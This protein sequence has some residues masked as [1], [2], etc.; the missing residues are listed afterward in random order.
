[1]GCSLAKQD[2]STRAPAKTIASVGSCAK[3]S[4]KA[5]PEFRAAFR[6]FWPDRGLLIFQ[7]LPL[8]RTFLLF[9]FLLLGLFLEGGSAQSAR[10]LPLIP[11]SAS[12]DPL[13]VRAQSYTLDPETGIARYKNASLTWQSIV[14]DGT[15]VLYDTRQQLIRAE[16]Y[17]R[18]SEGSVTAVME[19]L[20]RLSSTVETEPT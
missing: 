10:G 16:G 18:V 14:I 7:T 19:R 8:L 4:S 13:Q 12:R 11:Q 2:D 9:I 17:V 1:M 15:E 3:F 6:S 20:E 5:L